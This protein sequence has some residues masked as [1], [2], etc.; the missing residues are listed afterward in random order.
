MASEGGHA[1]LADAYIELNATGRQ[2]SSMMWP[3][4]HILV[5]ND[6]VGMG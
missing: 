5:A 4:G 6:A 2:P 3:V 1:L